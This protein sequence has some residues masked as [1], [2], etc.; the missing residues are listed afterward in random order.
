[1][2]SLC[3]VVSAASV[4]HLHLPTLWSGVCGMSPKLF[5]NVVVLLV[6]YRMYSQVAHT[7]KM[8][9]SVCVP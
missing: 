5:C 7:P 4:F 1:M 6:I 2:I 3:P 8:D 9:M